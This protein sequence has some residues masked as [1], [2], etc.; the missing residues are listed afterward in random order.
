MFG[1]SKYRL[2]LIA[3]F[4]GVWA[5]AAIEP[6]F[7]D[8]WLLENFLVFLIPVL[9][10]IFGKKMKWSDTSYTLLLLLAVLHL[11][12]SH[13]TYEHVPFGYTLGEWF[14]TTRNMYDRLVHFSFGLLMA[15]PARELCVRV[16]KVRGGWSYYLPVDIIM[17]LSA[18][19]EIIEWISARRVAPEVGLAFL[20]AQGDMWDAQ[21]DML[22]AGCGAIIA[23]IIVWTLKKKFAKIV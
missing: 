13:Y 23:M 6:L 10:I 20:G 16:A 7:P 11:I 3:I 15:Y 18:L 14:G 19:Y 2:F 1:L 5:L 4:L 12:G 21:S 9:L 8:D 17:S 22:M